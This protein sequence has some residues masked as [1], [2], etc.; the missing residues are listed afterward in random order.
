MWY[1]CAIDSYK[2]SEQ[3][4]RLYYTRRNLPEYFVGM[5]QY[6]CL[7]MINFVRKQVMLIMI[8]LH[9]FVWPDLFLIIACSISAQP[10]KG[11]GLVCMGKSF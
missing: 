10:K 7:K 6:D 4:V 1:A 5:G 8:L 3:C 11:S 2:C 9:S